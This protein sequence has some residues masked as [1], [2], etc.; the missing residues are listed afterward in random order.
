MKYTVIRLDGRYSY[1]QNFGFYLGF[2]MT[3]ARQHGP[4]DFNDAITWFTAHYGWSA[5]IRQWY[6]IERWTNPTKLGVPMAAG[7]LASPSAHC[8]PYW[9]WSNGFKD[10][11]I[12]TASEQELAFF[13]L[14]HPVDQKKQ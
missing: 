13:Q 12:Y 1:R 6:N 11:R 14:A 2:S 3:M 7:I 10:L 8:N 4:I 5:E 9:S